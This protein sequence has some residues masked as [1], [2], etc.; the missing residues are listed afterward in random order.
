MRKLLILL[1]CI[2]ASAPAQV[3]DATH[4]G[5]AIRLQ[6]NWRFQ[7][8]DNPQWANPAFDDSAWRLVST[9]K[10]WDSQNLQSIRGYVWYRATVKLPLAH[11]PLMLL[12]DDLSPSEVYIDGKKAD[13]YGRFP[14][15]PVLLQGHPRALPIPSGASSMAL[16]LRYWVTP[17]FFNVGKIA[18]GLL[19]GTADDIHQRIRD[20]IDDHLVQ[21]IPGYVTQVFALIVCLGLLV[22]FV[23]QRE[24]TEYFFL[25]L[26]LLANVF[27]GVIGEFKQLTSISISLTDYLNDMAAAV[28]LICMIEFVF[29]F[30]GQKVPIL[31]RVY[32][33]AWAFAWVAIWAAWHGL[34]PTATLNV[35]FLLFFLPYWFYLP[36]LLLVRF[37]RGS[38]EAGLLAIPLWLSNGEGVLSELSWVLFQLRLR[39]TPDPILHAV[40]LGIVAVSPDDICFFLF[41]LSVAALILMRFQK[42]RSAQARAEAEFEAARNMQE[43]MVPKSVAA[44]GFAIETAYIPAQEVGGDFFQM[45]PGDDGSLLVVIGDVSGKGLKAAMLVSMILGLLRRTVQQTRSPAAILG[46]LNSLLIG[47]TDE[48]FAT[49]CCAL[50]RHDGSMTAANAGHL[51]PYCDGQE[52]ELA[53]GLPLG[54]VPDISYEEITHQC[55][56]GK[57]WIFLSDGVVEARAKSGELYGFERTR[58]ISLRAVD[59]IAKTAQS[60]GQDDDITVLGIAPA[61]FA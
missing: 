28:M 26:A 15:D 32:Q 44:P 35:C 16:A 50:L 33:V 24:R 20:R 51:S 48:K 41:L 53:G 29:R 47:H 38:K 23:L 45:F 59:D 13:T 27:S 46:D 55:G 6:G 9:E 1:A 37:L 17:L 7:P 57:R 19:I 4:V 49:C 58:T 42:T 5:Q 18:D 54:L 56:R 34:I 2:T 21:Q 3:M 11:G 31:W 61:A 39:N 60:F 14:P 40:H 10:D 52:I 43:V 8:G 30:L 25:A 36:T 12:I 22:L